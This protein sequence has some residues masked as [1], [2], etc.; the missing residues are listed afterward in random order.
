MVPL[1]PFFMPCDRPTLA[2]GVV[3]GLERHVHGLS[4]MASGVAA[5]WGGRLVLEDDHGQKKG[6]PCGCCCCCCCCCFDSYIC[7]IYIIYS[8][9]LLNK[10]SCNKA[11]YKAT[12]ISNMISTKQ[13]SEPLGDLQ[14]SLCRRAFGWWP[15]WLQD[16]THGRVQEE[17]W[18]L[19]NV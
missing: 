11:S 19:L 7:I 14:T 2:V 6:N 18:R 5:R 13:P 10:L 1:L 3:E 16:P 12:M 9:K 17:C 8:R 4:E 15:C